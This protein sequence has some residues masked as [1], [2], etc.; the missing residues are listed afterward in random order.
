[1][2]VQREFAVIVLAAISFA[3]PVGTSYAAISEL[4]L[5]GHWFADGLIM[6]CVLN[7]LSAPFAFLAAKRRRLLRYMIVTTPCIVVAAWVVYRW[8][9]IAMIGI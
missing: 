5:R 8:F 3:G 9:V 4:G 1:V 2:S 6:S 7:G